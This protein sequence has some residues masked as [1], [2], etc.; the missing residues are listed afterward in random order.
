MSRE[1]PFRIAVGLLLGSFLA[2]RWYF[3]VREI[4]VQTSRQHHPLRE[5]LLYVLQGLGSL[6]LLYPISS[7]L[8]SFH[9]SLAVS[10]RWLGVMLGALSL[11]LFLWTHWT[12]GKNWSPVLAI[13][14][15]H[16]LV[17]RG[18]YRYVRHPMYSA[19]FI[20]GTGLALSSANWLIA[21]TYLAP[22]TLLYFVRVGSEEQMLAAQFG[23]SYTDYIARTG[24][25]VPKRPVHF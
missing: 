20:F 4:T 23:Q 17:V 2:I 22:F 1:T 13:R 18:P 11:A 24:R 16:A 5:R 15:D 14:T 25:L 7:L 19:F 9:I 8:D 12:L 10:I 21:I 3:Q 6:A